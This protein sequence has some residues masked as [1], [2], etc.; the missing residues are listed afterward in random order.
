MFNKGHVVVTRGINERIS[1]D[2]RFARFIENSLEKYS[3]CDWGDTCK[4]DSEMNDLAAKNNDDRI[5]ALYK[6][7]DERVF[8]ITD[9]QIESSH[10]SSV[11]TILFGSEY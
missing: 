4:E 10:E 2:E 3:A 6:Y 7:N 1:N 8:I 5:V 11:T 9:F